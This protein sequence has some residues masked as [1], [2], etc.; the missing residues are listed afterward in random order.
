MG[1]HER[2]ICQPNRLDQSLFALTK[3]SLEEPRSKINVCSVS[4]VFGLPRCVPQE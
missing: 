3:Q 2:S 4:S 1:P